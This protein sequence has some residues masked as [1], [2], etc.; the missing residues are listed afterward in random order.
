MR[1]SESTG[2]DVYCYGVV[3]VAKRLCDAA[4]AGQTVLT[5]AAYGAMEARPEGAAFFHLGRHALAGGAGGGAG[6]RLVGG[7]FADAANTYSLSPPPSS[8]F[9]VVQCVEAGL[10]RRAARFPPLGSLRQRA[11]GYFQA[12]S[13]AAGAGV[14]FV[15]TYIERKSVFAD[16]EGHDESV[17]T[18]NRSAREARGRGS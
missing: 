5:A 13:C 10:E 7:G 2:R 8:C 6:G 4:A 1:R 16:F 14:A 12:P 11:P 3:S 18:L 9:D 17:Q 15:F